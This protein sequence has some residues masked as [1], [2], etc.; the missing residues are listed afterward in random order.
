[1]KKV[2]DKINDILARDRR[3][4]LIFYFDKN[5]DDGTFEESLKAIKEA[6]IKVVTAKDNYFE[7]KYKLEM[8][9]LGEPVF[10]YHPFAKPKREELKE[11]PLLDLLIANTELKLDDVSEFITQFDLP[12]NERNLVKQ[13][14]KMLRLPSN[15]RK[16]SRVLEKGQFN[17]DNLKRGLISITLG[18]S[19]VVSKSL[20]MAKSFEIAFD[21]EEFEKVVKRLHD[22]ALEE[23][24]LAWFNNMYDTNATNLTHPN[25]MEWASKL[26]Y[27]LIMA[28]KDKIAKEDSYARLKMER[29]QDINRLQNFYE[30]WKE[31]RVLSSKIEPVFDE[32]GAEV[33]TENILKW[34]KGDYKFGYYTPLMIATIINELYKDALV[35]PYN[36]KRDTH[37]WLNDD[38]LLEVQQQEMQF[39]YHTTSAILVLDS[40]TSY[41]FDTP[42]EFVKEYTKDLY[43]VD[44]NFRK[45]VIAYEKARNTRYHMADDAV[46]LFEELNKRYD[47]F[48]VELNVEWQ[49]VLE[50][51]QFN[52]HNIQVDKQFDF[53]KKHL[54]DFDYKMV[55]IISDAFRYE[56]GQE[57]CND[58]LEEGKLNVELTPSLAS[59][60]SYTNLGMSNLLPNE[61]MT[62]ETTDSDLSFRIDGKTTVST[63]RAAILQRVE[64]ESATLSFQEAMGFDS[65]RGREFFRKNRI[66]YIY[67]N[68]IDAIGDQRS[69]QHETFEATTKAVEDIKALLGKLGTWNIRHA[70]VT[71]DHGFLYNHT[72]IKPQYRERLPKTKGYARE[73]VR[74]VVAEELDGPVDGYQMDLRNTTNLDTNLKV[75]IP[76]ATNRYHKQGNVGL[77]FVHGGASLQELLTP[78]LVVHRADKEESETV[79]FKVVEKTD[80]ITSSFMKIKLLQD[81]PVSNELKNNE[82][83]FAIYSETGELLSDEVE[84]NLNSASN[85]PKDRVVDIVLSLNTKG[86]NASIGWVKAYKKNNTMRINTDGMNDMVRISSLME[87]DEF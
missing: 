22:L 34:Y 83:V 12:L 52:F 47:R 19:S 64:P 84:V 8:E 25:M 63:N 68:W 31:H 10:I 2:V 30:D 4:Q 33:R 15:Q 27:N 24:V 38:A 73:H 81:Q 62:L 28:P 77:Q 18:F 43:K 71:S 32:L 7:L 87:K 80:R 35:N 37:G 42:E 55:V 67:H 57:L 48:L 72:E 44:A 56:L 9:W 70:R 6:G 69:T 46:L 3:K 11:Y 36:A 76:R 17:E 21:K 40:Y 39:I 16:L 58:L 82:L 41:I 50:E 66:V 1:M 79:T 51:K 78:T 86:T 14:I 45:A 49:R 23:K 54:K 26:K 29:T 5:A 74:F 59:V 20:C 60:P 61:G 13:Y 65:K 75:L 53:Y 85:N